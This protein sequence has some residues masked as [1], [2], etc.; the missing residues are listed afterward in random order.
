MNMTLRRCATA[1][2]GFAVLLSWSADAGAGVAGGTVM[3]RVTQRGYVT[4]G[5]GGDMPGFSEVDSSG[6]WRGL[7]IEFCGALASAVFGKKEAVKFL[8]LTSNDRFKALRSGD[9]DVLMRGTAW[10]LSRDT[11]LG[12]RFTDVL[13]YDGQGFLVPRNHS[14]TSVLELSGASICVLPGSSGQRAIEDYFGQRKMRYQLITSEKWE[15][16]V[17]AYS[18]GGCTVLTGDTTL[19]ARERRALANSSEHALL[20]EQISKEPIG[21]AVASGD[22][23]WFSIVRWTMMALI[24]AEEFGITRDN[25]EMM[26]ESRQLNV[27]RLLG[28]EADLG[29]PLGLAKDWAYKVIRN[30]GNYAEI[31]DRTMGAASTLKLDRGLNNTWLNGGLLYAAPF[32]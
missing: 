13:F 24:A 12:A 11:E 32:R 23:Q 17:A 27:R 25:A 10:T 31:F 18:A 9:V 2:V 16:L 7:D 14:I 22:E 26:L 8:D 4:C 1:L 19:L 21:P 15:Q 3:E 5:V 29:A 28:L 20:P 30:V 6:T